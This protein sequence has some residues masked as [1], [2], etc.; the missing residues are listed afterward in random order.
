V[1]YDVGD[2][3]SLTPQDSKVYRFDGAGRAMR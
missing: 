1:P 2:V 3:L